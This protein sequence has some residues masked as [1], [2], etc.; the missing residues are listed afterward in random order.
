MSAGEG[1]P[2]YHKIWGRSKELVRLASPVGV[3][4]MAAVGCSP[5]FGRDTSLIPV[6]ESEG[7]L[8]HHYSPPLKPYWVAEIE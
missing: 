6:G 3:A 7:I 4:V 5:H 8:S 2:S 1:R